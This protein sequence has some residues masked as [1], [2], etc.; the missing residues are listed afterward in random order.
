MAS[1]GL[2]RN[3]RKT[4]AISVVIACFVMLF[5]PPA[6]VEV[7]ADSASGLAAAPFSIIADFCS[8]SCDAENNLPNSAPVDCTSSCH[9]GSCNTFLGMQKKYVFDILH[10]AIR[11]RISNSEQLNIGHFV[12]TIF[13]PPEA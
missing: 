10:H 3:I 13:K 4:V 7:K 9:T 8:H 5:F 6:A 11:V 1:R 12:D 2:N